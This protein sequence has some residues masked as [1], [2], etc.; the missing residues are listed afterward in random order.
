MPH[1]HDLA[2]MG[3]SGFIFGGSWIA[4]VILSNSILPTSAMEVVYVVPIFVEVGAHSLCGIGLCFN[5]MGI[6]P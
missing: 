4:P 2:I 5:G 1:T 3:S 6:L